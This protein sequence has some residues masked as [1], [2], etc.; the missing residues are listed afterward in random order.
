MVS[1]LVVKRQRV[2]GVNE[3]GYYCDAAN[4]RR[5]RMSKGCGTAEAATEAERRER[6]EAMIGMCV[7][8]TS[9][10]HYRGQ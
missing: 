4:R 1:R 9:E 6:S 8:G 10:C 3:G 2:H 5:R 7:S